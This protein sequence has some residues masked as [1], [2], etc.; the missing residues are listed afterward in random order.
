MIWKRAEV[1]VQRVEENAHPNHINP[2]SISEI[3]HP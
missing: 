3:F 2:M 1:C